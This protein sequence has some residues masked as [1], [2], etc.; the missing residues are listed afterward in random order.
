MDFY[1][2]TSI[3]YVN[4]D[5][6]IGF[7]LEI[8]QADALA[9][10]RRLRGDDVRFLTGTDDNSLKNVQAAERQGIPVAELVNTHAVAFEALREPLNLSWDDFIRTS[11]DPRHR[12][13]VER[14][15]EAAA[16]SGD[17]YRKH[18]EGLYCVGC[19][20]FY[21]PDELVDGLCPSHGTEP[22]LVTEE[23]WFFRLSRYEDQLREL[24][25]TGQIR[26]EPKVRENEVLAFIE[27]GLR[28]FS[29]SRSVRRA[30]GW[31]IPVPGDPSQVTYVWF[32]ALGNYITALDYGDGDGDGSEAP[33]FERWWTGSGRQVHVIGKDIV[34]FHAI[35][36]P[37]FLLSA[38][39][40]LPREIF[41]HDFLTVNGQ[42]ISK[43]LG[44]VIDPVALTRTYGTDS[45]R[46]WLLSQ[47]PKV[48]D[49]DFTLDRL[50]S[51]ANRDL[52]GGIGNLAQ[53]VATMV[54]KYRSGVVPA[55]YADLGLDQGSAPLRQTTTELPR[56][57]D[58][59]LA[60]F[61][62][63]SA[64][65]AIVNAITE[66][67]RYV[68]S[69]APWILAK[70]ERT[71]LDAARELDIALRVLVD[72]IRNISSEL[73]PFVP[74]L[75]EKLASRFRADTLPAPEPVFPRIEVPVRAVDGE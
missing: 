38:G 22:Q 58:E 73:T 16:A 68:E 2:T 55:E 23:N 11:H 70:S 13:G 6:H 1:V 49:T 8:V 9:R 24:Y 39:L 72:T 36:W 45:L 64:A 28:D 59:A 29:V 21:E 19:E 48:G 40:R 50:I 14:L 46:W 67:N 7:S 44:N 53:R 61:D 27:R 65:A 51:T 30:R 3:P 69:V 71:N 54:H 25:R 60:V 31:G 42:K 43:S 20:A 33:A 56:L 63:R 17:L 66:A 62:F 47:V 15:W 12:P 4:A 34:R 5:P 32:D 57:V 10:H 18:Y 26:V 52:A 74:Q 41:V 75:A 35:Y 37:A